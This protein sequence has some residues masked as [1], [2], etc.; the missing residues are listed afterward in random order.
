[1][2]SNLK[3]CPACGRDVSPE[4][5]T[6]PQ[7]GQ[8]LSRP[9]GIKLETIG[10][11]MVI[12]GLLTFCASLGSRGGWAATVSGLTVVAGLVVFIVGRFK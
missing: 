11:L 10:A 5:L 6:C 4:A 3:P 7:C 1:M 9:A 2:R 12:V 8:P